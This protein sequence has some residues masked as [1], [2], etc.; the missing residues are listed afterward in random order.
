MDSK[1]LKNKHI[2]VV[3]SLLL[4]FMV[5]PHILEDFALG[6]PAKNGVPHYFCKWWWQV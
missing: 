2:A 5:L 6:E 1:A 4:M 3:L